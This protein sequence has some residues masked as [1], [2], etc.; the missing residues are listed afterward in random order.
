[1]SCVVATRWRPSGDSANCTRVWGGPSMSTSSSASVPPSTTATRFSTSEAVKMRFVAGSM[2]SACG[3][4]KNTSSS[5]T[6]MSSRSISPMRWGGLTAIIERPTY[7]RSLDGS[8]DNSPGV[9]KGARLTSSLSALKRRTLPPPISETYQ[10]LPSGSTAV[11]WGRQL[12][13]KPS[14]VRSMV[15]RTVPDAASMTETLAAAWLAT[16]TRSAVAVWPCATV[17]APF[18]AAAAKAGRTARSP[19]TRAPERR[20]Y[21][22]RRQRRGAGPAWRVAVRGVS[23]KVITAPFDRENTLTSGDGRAHQ[24]TGVR[25]R[26]LTRNSPCDPEVTTMTPDAK[27]G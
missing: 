7:S 16:Y 2:V 26:F 17:A 10:W 22:E 6:V 13:S 23:D 18:S 1:M 20:E 8:M 12:G 21:R 9:S 27:N 24:E 25:F 3:R 5:W 19:W 15:W 11:W 4:G 14:W